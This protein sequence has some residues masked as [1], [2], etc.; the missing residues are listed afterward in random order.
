VFTVVW[1]DEIVGDGNR[2]A[3]GTQFAITEFR[4]DGILPWGVLGKMSVDYGGTH[5]PT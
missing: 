2:E 5:N 4:E 1:S 3:I